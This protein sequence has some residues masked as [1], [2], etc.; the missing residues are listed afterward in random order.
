MDASRGLRLRQTL[1]S[2][3]LSVHY[4]EVKLAWRGLG[5]YNYEALHRHTPGVQRAWMCND[6]PGA[7][8]ESSVAFDHSTTFQSDPM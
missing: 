6:P 7:A 4:Y 1:L 2:V 3:M 8:V 5:S